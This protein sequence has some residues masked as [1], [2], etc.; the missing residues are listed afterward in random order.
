MNNANKFIVS[1]KI[2]DS[3]DTSGAALPPRTRYRLVISRMNCRSANARRALGW[4]RSGSG[5]LSR[6]EPAFRGPIR[7][8]RGYML[9]G[10]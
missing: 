4:V 9:C 2:C 3:L 5:A 7:A 8:A 10:G 1:I 6:T